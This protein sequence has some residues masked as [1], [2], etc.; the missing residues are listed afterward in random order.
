MKINGLEINNFK[1]YKYCK[2]DLSNINTCSI[3]GG[4]GSGKSSLAEAIIWGLFNYSKF[5]SAKELLHPNTEEMSV[6]VDFT[7]DGHDYVINRKY[8]GSTLA[9]VT[10]DGK[11]ITKNVSAVTPLIAKSIGASRELIAESVLIQQGQL[12]S[13]VTATPAERRDIIMAMLGMDKYQKAWS[14]AKDSHKTLLG[15]LDSY[16]MSLST[17]ND[18]LNNVP[19]IQTIDNTINMVTAETTILSTQIIALVDLEANLRIQAEQ[20]QSVMAT[21]NDKATTLRQVLL[22]TTNEFNIKINAANNKLRE[23]ENQ[24]N[25][26]V[27]LTTSVNSLQDQLT[28]A[29]GVLQIIQSIKQD[30]ERY[31][32]DINE[33]REK[34]LVASKATDACPLCKNKLTAEQWQKVL[35]QMQDDL[36]AAINNLDITHK[37][38]MQIPL[39]PHVGQVESQLNITKTNLIKAEMAKQALPELH[40]GLDEL[41]FDKESSIRGLDTEL[42]SALQKVSELQTATNIEATTQLM[43]I[44]IELKQIR[45]KYTTLTN[46]LT[47]WSACKQTREALE[48]SLLNVTDTMNMAKNR[49]PEIEFVTSALSPNGIPMLLID[50]YLPLVENKAKELLRIM[51]DGQLSVKLLVDGKKVE[52]LAG[53]GQLRPIKSLSGGE[54]TRVSLALRLALSRILFEMA[55]CKFDC[56]IIDEPEYL[57]DNGV[58][59]FISAIN[60]LKSLFSQIFVIS[61]LPSIKSAMPQCITV[62]KDQDIS[63]ANIV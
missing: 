51:S 29:H 9:S 48:N 16:N 37:R 28:T 13:F 60:N 24:G 36:N 63:T 52:L 58:S 34:I 44:S 56:L 26:I 57:D 40:K 42:S 6:I 7:I 10:I 41:V 62:H 25:N 12:S 5:P 22:T 19:D 39:P 14:I 11:L 31:N 21:W 54:Q 59:Q 18:Q 49:L 23:A 55:N 46:R 32:K 33:H 30:I 17:I 4:N 61:H 15:T 38:L 45:D 50:Y 53:A 8:D 3:V 43:K 20:A 47:E 2:L 35:S 1:S 27:G